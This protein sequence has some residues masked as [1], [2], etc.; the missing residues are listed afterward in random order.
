MPKKIAILGSTGSIGQSALQVVQ[1]LKPAFQVTGLTAY[2]NAKELAR[3][4]KAFK[5]KLAAIADERCYEELKAL[6]K[7]SRTRLLAG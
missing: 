1:K 5:P 2:R 4:I 7:G 6:T 3:Q